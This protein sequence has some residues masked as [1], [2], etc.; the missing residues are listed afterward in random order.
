MSK[1]RGGHSRSAVERRRRARVLSQQ[2]RYGDGHAA[3]RLLQ[4]QRALQG[5]AKRGWRWRLALANAARLGK[6]RELVRLRGIATQSQRQE[7]QSTIRLDDGSLVALRARYGRGGFS[8]V[9]RDGVCEPVA[10]GVECRAC[11]W[12]WGSSREPHPIAI[13]WARGLWRSR[14]S[15]NRLQSRASETV[16]VL[17]EI[18]EAVR[19]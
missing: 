12:K 3:F 4:R 8:A 1:P 10:P 15:S 19:A 13:P 2:M 17:P 7:V 5:I 14:R 11:G 9:Y 18:P 6:H 16:L